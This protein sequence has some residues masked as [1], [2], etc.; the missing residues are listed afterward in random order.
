MS[1]IQ[2]VFDLR[3]TVDADIDGLIARPNL[4]VES[5]PHRL[6][7]TNHEILRQPNVGLTFGVLKEIIDETGKAGLNGRLSGF[8][9]HRLQE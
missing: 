5:T 2:H 4:R 9:A 1:A 8:N 6:A 3:E 7:V